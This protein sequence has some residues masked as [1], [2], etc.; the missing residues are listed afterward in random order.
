MAASPSSIGLRYI[1]SIVDI[2]RNTNNTMADINNSGKVPAE[3]DEW[4]EQ[5]DKTGRDAETGITI[6]AVRAQELE[7]KLLRKIDTRILPFLV[8]M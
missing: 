2:H 6:D 8:L 3:Q 1:Y 5:I 4:V 7:S